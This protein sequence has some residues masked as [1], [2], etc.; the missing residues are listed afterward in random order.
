M[1]QVITTTFTFTVVVTL[2]APL[3]LLREKV[4]PPPFSNPFGQMGPIF[5][6]AIEAENYPPIPP[7]PFNPS[8][9]QPVDPWTIPP[10][11]PPLDQ[12]GIRNQSRAVTGGSAAATR[13]QDDEED[14]DCCGDDR[15]TTKQK[16]DLPIRIQRKRED[17]E[18]PDR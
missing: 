15:K 10:T 18:P 7:R 14:A 11:L 5:M 13:V 12:S 16:K 6:T 8:N 9:P 4:G 3:A 17:A 1:S 2:P